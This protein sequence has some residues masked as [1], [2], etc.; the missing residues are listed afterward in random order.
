[1]VDEKPIKHIFVFTPNVGVKHFWVDL[2]REHVFAPTSTIG[3]VHMW[4]VCT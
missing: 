1:L 2:N 3:V 4:V